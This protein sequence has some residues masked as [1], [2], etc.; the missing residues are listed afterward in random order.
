MHSPA[1]GSHLADEGACH[2]IDL[3]N[4]AEMAQ[5]MG[6]VLAAGLAEMISGVEVVTAADRAG[7][8]QCCS[9]AIPSDR[10]QELHW[11]VVGRR[12][13]REN[14]WHSQRM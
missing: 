14:R 1:R 11:R 5:Q 3:L 13:E 10:L 7:A 4:S 12:R 6:L 2:P 9:S 8:G